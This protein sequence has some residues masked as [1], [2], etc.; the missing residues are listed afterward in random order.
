[1]YT[2]VFGL[3]EGN[4]LGQPQ[5]YDEYVAAVGKPVAWFM[6]DDEWG[7]GRGF[8]LATAEWIRAKG[9]V[10]YIRL[11][12]RTDDS[13]VPDSNFTLDRIG[14]GAFDADLTAWG[15]AAAQFGTPLILEYGTEVN[16]DWMAWN[17]SYAGGNAQATA[18][19]RAAYRHIHDVIT[20]AGATNTTWVFHANFLDWPQA[21]W[22]AFENYYPGDDVVDWVGLSLYASTEITDGNWFDFT[23]N[24]DEAV[25][26][27]DAMAPSKPQFVLEFAAPANDPLGDP[28]QWAQAALSAIISNR[29]PHIRGF[30]WWNERYPIDGHAAHDT[31]FQVQQIPGM[32]ALFQAQLADPK[33]IGRPIVQ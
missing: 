7:A 19:F 4:S 18:K 17:G 6:V 2:G 3:T 33:V 11:N 24:M 5:D 30:N 31:N 16:G 1:M 29:W 26:R 9:A 14:S 8:P 20:A 28:V 32:S 27:L 22:N 25:A 12:L 10:P 15:Q 13:T 21:S 23:S